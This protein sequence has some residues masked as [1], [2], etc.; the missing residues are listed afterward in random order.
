MRFPKNVGPERVRIGGLELVRIQ[1][2]GLRVGSIFACRYERK[3]N[4]G[5]MCIVDEKYKDSAGIRINGQAKIPAH[6]LFQKK[7][8]GGSEQPFCVV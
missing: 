5:P 2:G 3:G 7:T 1:Q 8:G 6:R 4:G